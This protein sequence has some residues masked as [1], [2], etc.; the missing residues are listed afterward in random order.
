MRDMLG[1]RIF[2]YLLELYL[3]FR[4]IYKETITTTTHSVHGRGLAPLSTSSILGLFVY[5]VYTGWCQIPPS[6][7]A[8][9]CGHVNKT[10]PAQKR[11]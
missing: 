8:V 6:T 2:G 4:C 5:K 1:L 7:I 11:S 3:G 10:A 9:S